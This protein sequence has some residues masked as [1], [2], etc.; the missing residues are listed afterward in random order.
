L[1][2][3]NRGLQKNKQ[4]LTPSFANKVNDALGGL[5]LS[6]LAVIAALKVEVF[7]VLMLFACTLVCYFVSDTNAH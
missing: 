2:A 6:W 3:T 5:Y 7:A 1:H 4:A